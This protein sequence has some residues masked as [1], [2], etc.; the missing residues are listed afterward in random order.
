MRYLAG[1]LGAGLLLA[2]PAKKVNLGQDKV[3]P[4]WVK[5]Q[6]SGERHWAAPANAT[7]IATDSAMNQY[8]YWSTLMDPIDAAGAY[9][10]AWFHRQWTPDGYSGL[11]KLHWTSDGGQTWCEVDSVNAKIVGDYFANYY[12]G[13]YPEATYISEDM[14]VGTWPELAEGPAWGYPG[15]ATGYQDGTAQGVIGDNLGVHKNDAVLMNNGKVMTVATDAG[16]V[17]Y[18]GIYDPTTGQY[19][20]APEA[21]IA[22]LYLTGVDYDPINDVTYVFGYDVSQGPCYYKV[23]PDLS[24]DGPYLFAAIPQ[25]DLGNGY[26]LDMIWSD[27]GVLAFNGTEVIPVYLA[28]LAATRSQNDTL[29]KA[30]VLAT[31]DTSYVVVQLTTDP[32]D[33]LYYGQVATD[34][35]G[36]LVVVYERMTQADANVGWG[37]FDLY[38]TTSNVA[39]LSSWSTPVNITETEDVNESLLHIPDHFYALN[40]STARVYFTY[41][42]S[43][44]G[45]VDLYA[46]TWRDTYLDVTYL[47]VGYVDVA[48]DVEESAP[49]QRPSYRFDGRELHFVGLPAGTVLKVYDITGR[50]VK[51]VK[52]TSS[53]VSLADLGSGAYFFRAGKLAG[54]VVVR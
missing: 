53:R 19:E 6:S 31:E 25:I 21:L 10:L 49:A 38:Y 5:V 37:W 48:V 1:I 41:A 33:Y 11:L 50:V 24:V 39:D 22:D 40:D 15:A 43:R 12:G 51:E 47:Y 2:A 28:G 29:E 54:K 35:Y 26:V 30:I 9:K 45:T 14:A 13:R 17:I 7:I 27:D 36:N 42:T 32:N 8:T 18:I 52:L 16:Q 23:T 46:G 44:D 20:S 34:I 4:A 3:D